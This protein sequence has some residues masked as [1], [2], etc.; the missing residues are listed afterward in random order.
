MSV[1]GALFVNGRANDDIQD[2]DGALKT[3]VKETSLPI[4]GIIQRR[5]WHIEDLPGRPPRQFLPAHGP[6]P[7]VCGPLRYKS[8]HERPRAELL[9]S[10]LPLLPNLS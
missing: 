9:E 10:P 4:N 3:N 6:D 5:T 8:G 2:K 7:L 1:V